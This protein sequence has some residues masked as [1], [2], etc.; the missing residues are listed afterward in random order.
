MVRAIF[1]IIMIFILGLLFANCNQMGIGDGDNAAPGVDTSET[2]EARGTGPR[3]NHAPTIG[4]GLHNVSMLENES[5]TITLKGKDE[6]GDPIRFSVP[7]L[8]SLR[9]LF[10]DG[11]KAIEILTGG[12][13]LVIGFLP[14]TA[15]GN[16]RFRIAL[17]DTA[18][19]VEEQILTI[20]VGKVNR[21]PSVSFA[22]PATG[23]AF[24]IKEGRTISLKIVT[25]DKDGDAV[26][27]Q[28][29]ANP[30]W[31]RFGQ[32]SYDT[33]S[34][35]LTFT[36]S[37][38]C[39]SSGETTFSDLVFRAKDNGSPSESGQIS[40]RITVQDSNSAPKWKSASTS[41]PGQEGREMVLDLAPLF[42]GDDEKDGVE[43]TATHGAVDKAS[44][45]WTFTPGFRDAGQKECVISASDSHKPPLTSKLTLTLIIADSVRLVDVAILSPVSGIITKDTVVPVKWSVGDQEQSTET[46]ET[47]KLEGPNVI[48]RSYRDSL[49]NNGSDSVT[50]I[51][52]S[53]PALPPRIS[54]PALGN[55]ASPRWTWRSGGE[56]NGQYRVSLDNSDPAA[57]MVDVLDTLYIPATPLSEGRHVLYVREK[58]D[59]GNWSAPDS[60]V[61]RIDLTPPV[62]KIVSPLTGLWT[63]APSIEVKWTL[64]G[65]EQALQATESLLGDGV[66]QIRREAQ[67]SAGNRGAD[68]I[69]VIRKSTPASAPIVNGNAAPTRSPQWTWTGGG[70]GGIGSY[71][72]GWTDGAWF[73]TLKATAYAGPADLADGARNL[74]VSEMDSAGNWSP[75][76]T[77]QVTVDK[78]PPVLAVT[79][80]DP[81]S[82]IASIDPDI[83]GTAAE[84]NGLASVAWSAP[85]LGTGAA[86]AKGN[87]WTAAIAYP[88][89]D[90][91][92]TLTAQ[93]AAGNT[94]APVTVVIHKRPNT[95]FVR[96]GYEGNG[97]SWKDAYGELHQALSGSIGAGGVSVWMTEGEYPSSASGA[98][99][100]SIPAHVEV[101]GGFNPDGSGK[102]L[103]DRNLDDLKTIILSG[104][105]ADAFALSLQGQTG[106]LDGLKFMGTG[107]AIT[108]GEGNTMRNCWILNTGGLIPVRISGAKGDSFQ[109]INT[110]IEGNVSTDRGALVIEA[111]SKATLSNCAI[112]GNN[113]TGAATGGG[114]W[115]GK[116]AKVT[117]TGTTLTG[118]TVP[119]SVGVKARQAH[120]EDGAR[121]DLKGTVEGG[122][123]GIEIME[124]ARVKLNGVDSP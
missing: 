12:D 7:N 2:P 82:A 24:R 112:T 107:G 27:L 3:V 33:K 57:P 121:L 122:M 85:G 88:A 52:D 47:L 26:T 31:P 100:L 28:T 6:D 42:Q 18:G 60:G 56:G 45:K 80:P 75:S 113:G 44:L 91:I 71:R 106:V 105:A 19:A 78:T 92:V 4:L 38:Q 14:G 13:S 66:V 97:T 35:T 11:K 102:T 109:L 83:T 79:G 30:P 61:T 5:K 124:G 54:V 98:D 46:S 50:V 29:L 58:D 110:R 69:L 123:D 55:N 114:L 49:G 9:A 96:K 95:R 103:S 117:A 20:S 116:K 89:G 37:F 81:E 39:V 17:M 101:Y 67:D 118:N 94:S 1:R 34:G 115:L 64:D 84:A 99:P 15:K 65:Q 74:Y 23:T 8:D 90:H 10:T 72:I 36:P 70:Q 22:A 119:D 16:Y 21:P 41:V 108:S 63:S 104:G 48:V 51:R 43:F 87:A 62:V 53:R 25:E 111:D 68:S 93:D 76:G 59:A 120:V 73:D 77:F 86:A 32:G 40:A